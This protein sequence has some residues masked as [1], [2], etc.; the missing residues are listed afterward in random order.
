MQTEGLYVYI[1]SEQVAYLVVTTGRM[2]V[3]RMAHDVMSCASRQTLS[4]VVVGV[5]ESQKMVHV[6]LQ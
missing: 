1:F 4:A 3:T 2:F 6:F 5:F